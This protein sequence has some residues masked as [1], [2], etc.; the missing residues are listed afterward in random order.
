[1][2]GAECLFDAGG[3]YL[4]G[5][6]ESGPLSIR[7]L[8]LPVSP[9]CPDAEW[10]RRMGLVKSASGDLVMAYLPDNVEI[11]IDM[12]AFPASMH[13]EWFDPVTGIRERLSPVTGTR[14][15][16]RRA[17]SGNRTWPHGSTT[18]GCERQCVS[19]SV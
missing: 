19:T 7:R 15:R 12:S 17:S 13:A 11:I 6:R 8:R 3:Q 14:P 18:R 5:T 16:V 2:G 1:V 10:L 4:P 9:G